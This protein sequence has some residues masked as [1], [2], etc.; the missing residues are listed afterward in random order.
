[1]LPRNETFENW[2]KKVPDN[3][4][5]AVKANSYITHRKYLKAPE[6]LYIQAE[7]FQGLQNKLGPIL[8]QL[9]PRWAINRQRLKDFLTKLPKSN[10]YAFEFR[11]STWY[12]KQIFELL[13]KHNCA[14]CIHD[15]TNAPPPEVITADFV[16]VR[17]HG[18]RG[19]Y[20]GKYSAEQIQAWAQKITGWQKTQL[21]VYIYFNN[22]TEGFAIE[23]ALQLKASLPHTQ[24]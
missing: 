6:S 5:F 22:D 7:R 4:L 18:T 9:P 8:F 17:L 23:N 11:N 10:Q 16:Y 20:S 19:N 1:M 3:F 2:Y 12:T 14:L 15:H 24:N 21:G 13:E